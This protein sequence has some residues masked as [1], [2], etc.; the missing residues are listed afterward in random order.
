MEAYQDEYFIPKDFGRSLSEKWT[1]ENGERF[2]PG[3]AVRPSLN[4]QR[5]VF[6]PR[7]SP[8]YVMCPYNR[9]MQSF[10]LCQYVAAAFQAWPD[11]SCRH[12][13]VQDHTDHFNKA[14]E[15]YKSSTKEK[16]LQDLDLRNV[17]SWDDVTR[18]FERA[19]KKYAE[20]TKGPLGL[21]RKF[22]RAVGDRAES[23][24]PFI[25][26]IPDSPYT[27]SIKAALFLIFGV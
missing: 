1:E 2:H 14:L 8:K 25:A 24:S 21:P 13:V 17:H 16:R 18:E 27:S 5:A 6:V 7:R 20:K 12:D 4:D 15:W 3:L 19:Q 9:L 22:A 23:I 11:H 10:E 26:F